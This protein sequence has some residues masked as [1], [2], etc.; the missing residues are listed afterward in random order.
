M[1][2]RRKT[3]R[4]KIHNDRR[5]ATS[6]DFISSLKRYYVIEKWICNDETMGGKWIF[7]NGLLPRGCGFASELACAKAAILRDTMVAPRDTEKYGGSQGEKG[8]SGETSYFSKTYV[9]CSDHMFCWSWATSSE[10]GFIMV[11]YI[12]LSL[13]ED[14]FASKLATFFCVVTPED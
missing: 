6:A 5:R 13:K 1:L 7:Q 2:N 8:P 10:N 3:W 11:F 9:R 12:V 4:E 14:G